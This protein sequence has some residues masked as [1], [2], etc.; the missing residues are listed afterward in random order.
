MRW[1]Q[2]FA[3]ESVV[4]LARSVAQGRGNDLLPHVLFPK[5]DA[6]A[7]LVA[8]FLLVTIGGGEVAK[9]MSGSLTDDW[10]S[11]DVSVEERI[12]LR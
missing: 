10:L 4:D 6:A 9:A 7:S 5:P 8:A 11:L 3:A 12:A 1:S 2:H